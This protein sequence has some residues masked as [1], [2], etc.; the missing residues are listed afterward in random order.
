MFEAVAEKLVN[1]KGEQKER[2]MEKTFKATIE[3]SVTSSRWRISLRHSNRAP[4]GLHTLGSSSLLLKGGLRK[5]P[6]IVG[7]ESDQTMLSLPSIALNRPP[8]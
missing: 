7:S 1:V 4:F 2:S 6:T 5:A 3:H 8:Y